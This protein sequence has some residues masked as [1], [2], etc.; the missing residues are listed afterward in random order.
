MKGYIEKRG[1][2]WKITI[3]VGT[4][5]DGKRLRHY[6]TVKGNKS[7]ANAR[8]AELQ[9]E[10]AKGTHVKTPRDL[11]VAGYLRSWLTDYVALNCAPKTQESYQ[12]LAERHVIPEIG[13]IKL[14]QLEPRHLQALYGRKKES[15]L[16]PRT[17]RYLYSLMAQA[18]G[19]AVKLGLVARNVAKATDPPRLDNK[20]I[21]TLAP[22][23]VPKFLKAA[24][25]SHYALFYTLLHTGMRRGEALALK[26][27]NVDM[28][29]ASLGVQ[30]YISVTRS[31]SK[32][33]G[34]RYEKEPK[35]ASG[36]RRIPLPGSLIT[37]LL[38]HKRNQEAMRAELGGRLTD[39]DYVFCHHDGTPLD[40]S[41]VSHAFSKVLRRAGLPSMPLH[42]LRHSHATMCLEAGIN[43]KI[44]GMLSTGQVRFTAT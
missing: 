43:P 32:V 34:Q 28:G 42:S 31:L 3:D 9:V 22:E 11:T 24:E 40:P 4:G 18:L 37:V 29:L 6:E 17:V 16:S 41:T 33:N 15:G 38:Q 7:V 20:D 39:E 1:Q 14:A 19:Q 2:G 35:T 13:M 44:R 10:L 21:K 27:K 8:L 12:Q 25:D 23:D 30:A 26:W 36:K 5:P